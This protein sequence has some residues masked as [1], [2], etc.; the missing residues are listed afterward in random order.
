MRDTEA[1]GPLSLPL[2]PSL[3][4]RL[5]DAQVGP[6]CHL[7]SV[8]SSPLLPPPEQARLHHAP[9]RPRGGPLRTPYPNPTYADTSAPRPSTFLIAHYVHPPLPSRLPIPAYTCAGASSHPPSSLLQRLCHALGEAATLPH[10]SPFRAIT[11][12][13]LCDMSEWDVPTHTRAAASPSIPPSP[14]SPSL[15]PPPVQPRLR[16]VPVRPR[17]GQVVLEV[18]LVVG[19][20]AHQRRG[21]GVQRVAQRNLRQGR[22]CGSSSR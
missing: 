9:G 10:S 19:Q 20:R 1:Q 21:G 13:C 18:A 2:N 5:C 7:S 4:A 17:G 16:H 6:R 11:A 12:K 15:L 8:P 3:Q 14:P 22:H